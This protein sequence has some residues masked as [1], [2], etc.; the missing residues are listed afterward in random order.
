MTVATA[1]PDAP[2]A[3]ANYQLAHNDRDLVER[4]PALIIVTIGIMLATLMQTLDTTIVNVALV[5]IQGNLGATLDESAWVVTGYII[6]AVIVI[7]ITPWLQQRF[8]RRQYYGTAIIG[9]TLAS[10]MCGLSGSITALIFWRIVQGLFGGGLVATA[11]ATL[12]DTFPPKMLGA[13]QAIFAIGALVG[14]SV[15]PIVG[16]WLTDNVSWNYVFFINVLPGTLAAIIVFSRLKNPTDPKPIPID[17]IGLGLLALGLGSLQFIL[18]EGQRDDWFDS[19]LICFF[20]AASLIGLVTFVFWELFGTT[21]PIVDLRAF[22]YRAVLAGTLMGLAIG[23]TLYGATVILPQYVQGLLN[24]TA[25]LSGLLIFLRAMV[26]LVMTPFVAR[27]ASSGKIDVRIFL[28]V[29]FSCIGIA[30]FWLAALT[31]TGNDF[32]TL[33]PPALLSGFGLSL[34]FVP[35]SIAVLSAL[36]PQ[37]I[38]KATAFQS[39]ALQLG[40]SFSTAALVTLLAQRNAFHQSVLAGTATL[41]NPALSALVHGGGGTIGALYGAIL[42]QASAMSFADAQFALGVL[43][44]ALMPFILVMPKRR[45]DAGHIE[46]AV[47]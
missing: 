43:C 19:P 15:G 24:F 29:G 1:P 2:A 27:V 6:S 42:T 41:T 32:P 18:D 39:L 4:G 46:I 34:V 26:I 47:E 22:R 45:K 38:P 9:F 14:P 5:Q 11:Q 10:I 35:L 37:I 23:A 40:G 36:P 28:T 17:G 44:F 16:G 25:S 7:P 20:A 33:V 8:G 31:T 13:S 21:R 3:P 12:R 30:Q